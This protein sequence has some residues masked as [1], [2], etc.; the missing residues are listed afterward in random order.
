LS[1]TTSRIL[2]AAVLAGAVVSLDARAED[3]DPPVSRRTDDD[4]DRDWFVFPVISS[5]P[6]TGLMLG[7]MLMRFIPWLS[8][9][10]QASRLETMGYATT[11]G[12]QSYSIS[13]SLFLWGGK[14]RLHGLAAIQ[15]WPAN[16]YGIGYDTPDDPEAYDLENTL[17]EAVLE[18]RLSQGMLGGLVYTAR[19]EDMSPEPGGALET[20]GIP[21][22][23][24][25]TYGG[26]GIRL[27]FDSRDNTNAPYSGSVA[28]YQGL[29]FDPSLGSDLEFRI[30]RLSLRRYRTSSLGHT[31][32][33]AATARM[34]RGNVPFR[35]LSTPDGVFILRGIEKR[36]YID[37][38]M[39][40]LQAEYRIHSRSAWG[41]TLFGCLA[42][43][44]PK[45]EDFRSN[46]FKS[47]L[48]V[49]LRYALRPEDRSNIRAD[50]GWVEGQPGLILNF[51]EAF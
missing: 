1:T 5:S 21:G 47:S 36:R 49:G 29:I 9:E 32:A 28:R 38:D 16:F 34:S 26:L 42:Q 37:N 41:M 11:N 35:Y 12:Q 50:I 24:G 27:G 39:V 4:R 51:R 2:L 48:G 31:A 18:R 20:G 7:A 3:E 8:W 46:R 33:V 43:V 44:A 13:P 15:L 25:G 40:A 22:A 30:Q 17:F 23:L 14:Y 45:I 10:L 19:R 6:E